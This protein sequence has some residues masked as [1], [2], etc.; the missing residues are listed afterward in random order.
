M[1]ILRKIPR[2]GSA[3]QLFVSSGLSTLE[4]FKETWCLCDV[5]SY[6]G[7]TLKSHCELFPLHI[8]TEGLNVCICDLIIFICDFNFF[9]FFSFFIL[10]VCG[11]GHETVKYTELNWIYKLSLY[12]GMKR[13]R[14][15]QIKSCGHKNV[16]KY[17][18]RNWQ[19]QRRDNSCSLELYI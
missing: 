7:C 4:H 5:Y 15:I 11:Y 17:V 8:H 10:P 1:R 18:H 13:F 16:Q 6:Y 9:L 3:S 2:G 19:H 14:R 12:F